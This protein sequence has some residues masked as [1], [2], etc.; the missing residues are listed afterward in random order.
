MRVVLAEKAGSCYGVQRALD[1]ADRLIRSGVSAN[2][3][4]P[5]IH[6][7]IVVGQLAERGLVAVDGI[8]ELTCDT[9]VIRSHGVMPDVR[10]A[11]EAKGLAIVDATCPH[12]ARAQAAASELAARYGAV[13]VVGEA[14]HPEVEGLCAYA[15]A[16]GARVDVAT[17]GADI[18]DDIADV[19]GVVVQTTQTA[20]AYAG[21]LDTLAARGVEVHPV[22]TVCMATKQ[23]QTAAANLAGTVDAMVVIGGRN[24]SNTT[25]LA[26]ICAALC[27][28]TYHIEHADELR[29]DWFIGCDTV[30]V[31]AGASTPSDQIESVMA[32]LQDMA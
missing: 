24:S 2:T 32:R 19:V 14:G 4:G 22:N 25:R 20:E 28:N 27:P 1:M 17:S 18:P 15:E 6:N 12:V 21:V 31:T 13:V 29:P 8:D 30:G 7:P 23:R 5:I 26:E 10:E 16:E 3:L 11:L 9:V